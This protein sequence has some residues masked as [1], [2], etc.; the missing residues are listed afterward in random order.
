MKRKRLYYVPGLISLIGLPILL[1]FYTPED[2]VRF[3]AIK[4]FLPSE[5][6]D[7]IGILEKFSTAYLYRTI[8]NKK[9]ISV[10][11]DE[12]R[13]G[14][15]PEIVNFNFNRKLEF[16]LAEMERLKFTHD[17][18]SVLKIQ[19]GENCS[20]GDFV[21]VLDK[22]ILYRTHKYT[23]AD[24]AFY[25]FANPPPQPPSHE[26]LIFYDISVP[27]DVQYI[28]PSKWDMFLSRAE[29]WWGYIASV[30][31]HNMLI[32]VG[33]FVLIV[34]PGIAKACRNLHKKSVVVK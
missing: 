19:L 25:I 27:R 28:S 14:T 7:S 31:R 17:T 6:K 13:I 12:E 5:T 22:T 20:F 30:M 8:S 15:D 4:V 10:D 21:W 16:I 18:S 34:V 1:L 3:C 33:F 26:N 9:I 32:L 24:N 23:F 2:T 29:E 11:L